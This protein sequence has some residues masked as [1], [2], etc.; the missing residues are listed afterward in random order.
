LIYDFASASIS[1]NFSMF[2]SFLNSSEIDSF[3]VLATGC[4]SVVGDTGV[5]DLATL[6]G[7][8][9]GSVVCVVSTG[10]VVLL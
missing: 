1:V 4:V 10:I 9:V 2:G 3:Q 8:A 7:V 5:S 6:L